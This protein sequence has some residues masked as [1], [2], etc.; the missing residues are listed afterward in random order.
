MNFALV[1]ERD[2]LTRASIRF[3]IF[4]TIL[5]NR[6]ANGLQTKKNNKA[7]H[8][9]IKANPSGDRPFWSIS[10]AP[11]NADRASAQRAA[12]ESKLLTRP[13]NSGGVNFWISREELIQTTLEPIDRITVLRQTDAKLSGVAHIQSIPIPIDKNP[14]KQTLAV[15][16]GSDMSEKASEAADPMMHPT[17][18]H[19]KRKPSLTEVFE[20]S[21][22]DPRALKATL[23]TST[24]P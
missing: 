24:A 23:R 11:T 12:P 15:L 18:T 6:K 19:P 4:L 5:Q 1:H 3:Y 10:I 9:R 20:G 17:P 7:I 21:D 13:N 14:P 22:S 16:R 2:H 8:P